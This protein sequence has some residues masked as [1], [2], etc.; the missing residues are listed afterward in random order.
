MNLDKS[1]EEKQSSFF[2]DISY[3]FLPYWPLFIFLMGFFLLL[4]WV[5]IKY[6]IPIYGSSSTILINDEKKGADENKIEESLN[7]LSS[8]KVVENEIEVIHSRKLMEDVVRELKLYTP[9]FE[10]EKVLTKSAYTTSPVEIEVQEPDKLIEVYEVPFRFNEKNKTVIFESKTYKLGEYYTTSYGVL[11]FN[12][13][14]NFQN[15]TDNPLFFSLRRP[16][17][18]TNSF[19]SS[20]SVSPTSKQSSIVNLF[21]QDEVPVR[22]ENILNTLMDKYNQSSID[23]KN[24]IAKSTIAFVDDRLRIVQAELTQVE[25]KIQNYKTSQGIVD[26]SS[27]GK[28]Y[29]ENAGQNDQRLSEVN[30][31]LAVLNQVENYVTN[32]DKSASIVPSTLGVNDPTLN[33]LLDRLY[34][35]Q[36][37]YERLSK[38]T[39]ENNP[40]LQSINDEIQKVRPSILDN[41]KNQKL[42]LETGRSSLYSSSKSF[43]AALSTIPQ[44]ERE[45]LNVS[46][47]QAIKN[48]VYSFLLQKREETALAYASNVANMKIVASAQTSLTPITPKANIIYL[49]AISLGLLLGAAI[50]VFK[51]LFTNKILFRTNIENLT[52]IPIIGEISNFSEKGNLKGQNNRA[53]QE[54]FRQLRAAAGLYSKANTIKKILLTSSIS[55]EGKSLVS[56]NLALSLSRSGKKVV[57]VDLDIRHPQLEKLFT[58]QNEVGMAQYLETEIPESEIIQVSEFNNLHLVTAGRTSANP[59][60]LLL[61]GKLSSFLTYLEQSFDFIVIDT[62]PV[63]PVTDAYILSDFCD[64]TLYVVRH[65]Y[66][67][68]SYIKKLDRN[69]KSM[70]LKNVA[71][72]FNGIKARGF[73]NKNFGYGYGYGYENKANEKYLVS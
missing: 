42:N 29:L 10:K 48:N 30:T 6:T 8:N 7:L 49:M 12:P 39:A 20:L 40:I 17:N 58:V 56:A 69:I 33:K 24:N 25:K 22:A 41:I 45:L 47:E 68:T 4:G 23:Y 15:N 52:K 46:R 16:K 55:G 35:S 32:K 19:L 31:Q 67:P 44:K 11:K 27:Q 63:G 36:L 28:M 64:L 51:D 43:N 53:I 66:T 9:T 72:I 2:E 65:N 54:Q 21:L 37:D 14:P 13:N 3:K 71:I 57:L 50:V 61:N 1:Q 70:P 38:T 62:S 18:I 73:I 5:Y 59:T 26:I 60:E 34:Q